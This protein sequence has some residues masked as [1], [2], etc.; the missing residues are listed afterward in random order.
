M[1][2]K[3]FFSLFVSFAL[4]FLIS[5]SSKRMPAG[6]N[7]EGPGL[8]SYSSLPERDISKYS[9]PYKAY[10]ET[11]YEWEFIKNIK[12]VTRLKIPSGSMQK[13]IRTFG[14]S[15]KM[16]NPSY[17]AKRGFI[18]T[19]EGLRINYKQIFLRSSESFPPLSKDLLDSAHIKKNIDPILHFLKFV[20]HL[21]YKIP[22][23]YYRGKYIREFFTPLICLYKKYGDCDT[24]SILLA[25]FLKGSFYK[26]E[27]MGLVVLRGFGIFH[28]ILAVKRKPLPGMLSFFIDN[29]G[30]FIPLETTRTGWMP[31][32]SDKRVIFCLEKG[33]FRFDKLF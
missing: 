30:P 27:E 26:K 20:Q 15:L 8:L 18:R 28:A 31:G 2:H 10:T 3:Y 6:N 13:D 23:K 32:F 11:E 25:S 9:V 17:L 12:I 5:I 16:D 22:P 14:I 29:N 21:K 1:K 4:I 7:S 19:R 24:K 33:K